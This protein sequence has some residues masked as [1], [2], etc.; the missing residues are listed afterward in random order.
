MRRQRLTKENLE[1]AK[2]D[3]RRLNDPTYGSGYNLSYNDGYFAMSLEDKW[4]DLNELGKAIKAMEQ[5]AASTE[6]AGI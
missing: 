1:E 4:G 5:E 6:G 2:K 3:L